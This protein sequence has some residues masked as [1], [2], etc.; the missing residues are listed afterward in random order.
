MIWPKDDDDYNVMV[1]R[2]T[3]REDYDTNGGDSL[4]MIRIIK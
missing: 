4:M 2:M 3:I 1:I